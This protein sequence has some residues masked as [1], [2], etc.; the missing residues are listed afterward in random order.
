MTTWRPAGNIVDGLRRFFTGGGCE[1]E[2]ITYCGIPTEHDGHHKLEKTN[3]VVEPSGD[4]TLRFNI[5]HQSRM[6]TKGI[7]VQRE[8]FERLGANSLLNSV[9]SI[10]DQFKAARE[11]MIQAR[12]MN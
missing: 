3:L 12:T 11:R 2:D 1:L 10:L 5:V 9:D 4:I 7:D 6:F 8:T